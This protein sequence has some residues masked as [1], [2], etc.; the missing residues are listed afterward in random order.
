MHRSAKTIFAIVVVAL[1]VF[2]FALNTVITGFQVG[3]TKTKIDAHGVCQNVQASDGKT[4]FIPTNTAAEWSAFR[5]NKPSG[6]ALSSCCAG[7]LYNGYCYYGMSQSLNLTCNQFCAQKNGCNVQAMSLVE[8]SVEHCSNVLDGVILSPEYNGS[9]AIILEY[10][11]GQPVYIGCTRFISYNKYLT[12][13]IGCE[14]VPTMGFGLYNSV[15]A[16][17][18]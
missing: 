18:Q 7:F 13:S 1:P 15:C 12:L 17:N 5:T 2:A 9:Q 8:E 10:W 11:Y 16:C 3:S 4:Y 6:V 14:R